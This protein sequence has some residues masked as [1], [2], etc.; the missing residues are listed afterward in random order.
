MTDDTVTVSRTVL[1][2][3]LATSTA[4]LQALL[5]E[6]AENAHLAGEVA[7][8]AA[9]LERVQR[10]AGER[11]LAGIRSH[12]ERVRRALNGGAEVQP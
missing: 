11:M 3:A 1:E 2:A 5:E 10:T 7:K 9:T 4:A 8:L 12:H 6:R